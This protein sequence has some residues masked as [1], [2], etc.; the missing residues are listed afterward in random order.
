MFHSFTKT[1]SHIV[2][3]EKF[4]FPFC[5]TPHPLCIEAANE[6][7]EYIKSQILWVE[8]LNQGKMFGVLVVRTD[9]GEIGYL[10]SFSGTLAGSYN[11]PYFVPPIYDLLQPDG[12][13][14]IEEENISTINARIEQI[15][16]DVYYRECKDLLE[17]EKAYSFQLL[18]DAKVSLIE[19]KK[20]RE[21]RR[22]VHPEEAE[23]RE[24]IR[25]SQFQKAEYKRLERYWKKRISDLHERVDVYEKKI[26]RLKVER[27]RRSAALQKELF[28]QLKILNARREIKDLCTIFE[29]EV[30]KIPPAGAGECAAP[31]LLQ[32]AYLNHLEPVAMAEFWWGDS[33][34]TEIRRHGYFYPSCK[35][36]C[37]PILKYMLQ[38]LNVEPNPLSN[39][40]EVETELEIVYED[41]YLLVINKPEG[42]LSVPGK[43]NADSVFRQM[44]EM[45]PAATGPMIVHR[46][47]MSTS[48]LLLIAKSKE[49]HQ[50]LQAQFKRRTVKKRYIALLDGAILNDEGEIN[51]P[52]CLNPDDRP[53]QMVSWKYGKPAMTQYK[54]LERLQTR[55][56]VAFCPITGRTH[57]L[58]VHA[59]HP[60]GLN[61]PI[62]GDRLYGRESD[63][64]YLHAEYLEFEHPIFSEIIR[65]EKSSSF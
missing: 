52:I 56:R 1:I 14:R 62:V 58:R 16:A 50:N 47:D 29:E 35:G 54:V 45:Y 34:K 6:L 20:T 46:L 23:L 51:L 57:Q 19:A 65:V 3:P 38:G 64:L 2:L 12:F 8:E 32:Y 43:N 44:R 55:T 48:G 28:A 41:E 33:P 7:Q 17:K 9:T 40:C 26:E 11:H 24:M 21:I 63:R 37:G 27:K 22:S 4:T 53:R 59:A 60:Q 25:E 42:L 10:A 13:F 31:K 15:Q 36:K 18:N 30:H 39:T 61:C 49:V 5:Y